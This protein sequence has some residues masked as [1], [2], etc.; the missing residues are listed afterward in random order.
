MCHEAGLYALSD[1]IESGNDMLDWDTMI[2][3]LSE[4]T[5]RHDAGAA[6]GYHAL[7]YGWLVG[8][9]A[10]RVAGMK[11]FGELL[12]SE[13][14]GPL[15]LDGLYCGVPSDQQYR[16]AELMARGFEA[17]TETRRRNGE[18]MWERARKW[19]RRFAA[20]G[21]AYRPTDSLAALAPPGMEDVEFNGEGMRSS[22]IPAANGM[23]TARS[24]ARLYA[25][26]ANGGE[27]D[28][29]RLLSAATV[30][31]AATEQNRGIGKVVPISMRWR[32]GYHRV[33]AIGAS[34]PTG[35]GHYGFGG[36]GAF[37]DPARELAVALTVN[38][39]V[40]TPFGDTR[41]GRIG[42]AA[43]RCADRRGVPRL[44]SGGGT[45]C[46]T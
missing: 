11:P 43:V 38:S 15:G 13:L 12:A 9:V 2:Q 24:L 30:R 14:A 5:P 46:A 34:V 37:A 32:M 10:R 41:I 45:K 19:D 17:S 6:H 39:G 35:F 23:F 29:T 1:M 18:A 25:C 33:M 28:G 3:R 8:E 42:G 36:S 22:A 20:L 40:G 4:A 21:I 27:L 26:L 7:T 31:Q 44:V 16:C